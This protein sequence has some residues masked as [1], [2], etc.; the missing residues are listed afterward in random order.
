M[1]T[2][3]A[4]HVDLLLEVY[5]EHEKL[6]LADVRAAYETDADFRA[7]IDHGAEVGAR[8]ALECLANGGAPAPGTKLQ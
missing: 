7:D 5:A 3:H 1:K 6:N 8:L 2:I 4:Q